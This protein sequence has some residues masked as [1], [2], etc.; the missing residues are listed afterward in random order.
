[1]SGKR[2]IPAADDVE[3]RRAVQVDVVRFASERNDSGLYRHR[4]VKYVLEVAR[5]PIVC[6]RRES[7]F[8]LPR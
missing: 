6:D 4:A 1:M 7:G 2:E 5:A 3:V 8:S